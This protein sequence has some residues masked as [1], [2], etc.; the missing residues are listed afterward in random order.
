MYF[1]EILK[2][3]EQIKLCIQGKPI[4]GHVIYSSTDKDGRPIE[5]PNTAPDFVGQTAFT[6]INKKKWV[7]EWVNEQPGTTLSYQKF[8]DEN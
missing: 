8:Q 7:A 5:Y 3:K 2:N 4:V 6:K 1:E